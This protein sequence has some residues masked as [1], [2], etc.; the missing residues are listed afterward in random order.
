MFTPTRLT[1]ARERRRLTK[2]ALAEAIG[3]TPHSVLRYES[4]S[5]T[6]ADET[7]DRL[8]AVL[9][10]PR[11]FFFQSEVDL[12]SADAASFRSMSAMSAGERGAALAAG[13][14]AHL[15]SEWVDQRFDLPEPDLIQIDGDAPEVAA[16]SLR[17][18]WALG[19]RPLKNVIHL[20]EAKGVRIFS[21]VEDTTAV[22]AFSLWRGGRP[23]MFLNTLKS[24]ERS[25]FDACHELGHLILHRHGAPQG[26][27]AE[28]QADQ[29]ASSLLMPSNDVHATLPRVHTL[30]Q[31]IEAKKRWGVSVMAL[32]VRLARL[33]IITDW[34]YRSFSIQAT[35]RGYRKAEPFGLVREKSVIWQKVLTALWNERT[36]KQHIAEDLHVPA[37]ELE[38]FLFGLTGSRPDAE[39]KGAKVPLRLV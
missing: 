38:N 12:I 37:D 10:F 22:D 33:G 19:E 35:E 39:L 36:T 29:F 1:L 21:L 26:R 24:A 18:E 34:Q 11:P 16:R 7:V 27:E 2:K 28:A 13:T 31:V 30:N 17:E 25:R 8:S 6:P 32:I 20:L 3:V 23:F 9:R 5:I 14:L 15:F 4:G